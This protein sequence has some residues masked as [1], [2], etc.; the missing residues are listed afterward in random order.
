MGWTRT[1]DNRTNRRVGAQMPLFYRIADSA[2]EQGGTRKTTTTNISC[3]GVAFESPIS[4]PITARL[5]LRIVLPS[6]GGELETDATVV[7]IASELP[8]G[9]GYE[10]GV[11]FDLSTLTRKAALEKF[12]ESIDLVPY[13]RKMVSRGASDLHLSAFSPPLLRVYRDLLPL[14]SETLSPTRVEGLVC[15]ALNTSRRRQLAREKDISFPLLIPGVGRWRVNAYYQR[16]YIEATFHTIDPYIPTMADLGL[17]DI[18]HSLALSD[19]G[20]ILVTGCVGS[21][22]STTL[23]SMIGAINEH[24]NKV[25]VS[26]EGSI[27]YIH[28]NGR[29]LIKQREVASDTLSCAL[30]LQHVFRQDPDVIVID[31]APDPETMDLVLRGAEEGYLVIVS[32]PTPD[33]PSTLNRITALFPESQRTL[34]LNMLSGAL[35]GIVSQRLLPKLDKSG[36]ALATEILTVNDSVRNSIRSDRLDQMMTILGTVPGAQLFDTSLRQLIQRGQIS[37]ET[38]API[39]HDAE[40]LRRR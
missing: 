25:I 31:K 23:A 28:E 26:L 29:S 35:R 38:A 8:E 1:E 6:D 37:F 9:K 33:A 22:K 39:A 19:S 16:G 7:R 11:Q 27:E 5:R 30:A 14:D 20:L 10:Y 13:L 2:G 24:R 17:P 34:V 3:Q 40:S 36:L 4:I 32:F 18:V 12:V 21:G 15:G